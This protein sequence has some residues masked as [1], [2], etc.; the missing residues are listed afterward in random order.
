MVAEPTP[1]A[2]TEQ[3]IGPA[4]KRDFVSYMLSVIRSRALPDVRDGLKPGQRRIMYAMYESGNLSNKPYRKSAKTVGDVL[5]KYHPHGDSAVYDAMVRMAQA[6]SLRYPLIDGQGNWG[7]TD[8]RAAAMR[9]TEARIS[10]VGEIL[11]ADIERDTVPFKDNYDNSEREPV[12][13]PSRFPNLLVNGSTGIAVGMVTGMA[14]HNL[15]EVVSAIE[16]LADNPD[17]TVDELMAKIPAPD[18]PSGCYIVQNEGIRKAYATGRGYVTMRARITVEDLGGGRSR[19]AIRNLPYMLS[20]NRVRESIKKLID[21]GQIKGIVDFID[22]TSNRSGGTL[23]YLDL[24]RGTSPQ[25]IINKLYKLTPLQSN[26][27]IINMAVDANG[28]ESQFTLKGLL[29]AYL[30]HQIEVVVRKARFDL[31]KA[32]D[33]LELLAGFMKVLGTESDTDDAVALIRNSDTRVQARE[34]LKKRFGVNDR[35]ANAILDLRLQTLTST[36]TDS[37]KKEAEQ[38]TKLSAELQAL[39]ADRSLQIREIKA[40]LREIVRK[41]AQ[42]DDRRSMLIPDRGEITERD[43]IPNERIVITLTE[44][45]YIKRLN[46]QTYRQQG[47]GGRGVTGMG[48]KADDVISVMLVCSS[49]DNLALFTNRGNL[50]RLKAYQIDEA[51]RTAKGTYYLNLLDVK[52]GAEEKIE[53]ILAFAEQAEEGYL[54]FITKM[55]EGKRVSVKEFQSGRSGVMAISLREGDSLLEVLHTSGDDEIFMVS[56][57]GKALI[58]HEGDFRPRGRSA[59]T[60]KAMR[61]QPDDDWVVA[62]GVVPKGE[63]PA[64]AEPEENGDPAACSLMTVAE[65][66]YAKKTPFDRYPRYS[67]GS[68][69]V[70]TMDIVRA[71]APVA[72]ARSVNGTG[73]LLFITDRGQVVRIANHDVKQQNRDTKGVRVMNVPDGHRITA[74]EF[75]D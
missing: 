11:M 40:Y 5:G 34:A 20:R 6:S 4:V 47:R 61:L 74:V 36:E 21:K 72:A 7:G 66:G 26:F 63:P 70:A 50:Y 27:S 49:H 38:L 53:S 44:D 41:Y 58:C 45:G 25:V 75:I 23:I 13:L 3:P 17:V 22:A 39:I 67:R 64:E 18:F 43:L 69:G 12:V 19:L 35:Q 56:R 8:D 37:L 60:I 30:N 29:E 73:D 15:A 32:Q 10:P 31:G 33:R 52:G 51:Q 28:V 54:T 42:D 71:G 16:L 9:Y 2:I 24:A 65:N 46:E 14:P 59:G 62:A 57:Q 55:G 68:G 1:Q 48:M